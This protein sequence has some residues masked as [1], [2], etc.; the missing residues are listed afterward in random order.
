MIAFVLLRRSAKKLDQLHRCGNVY[1]KALM[2]DDTGDQL[3]V[4][5][6]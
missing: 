4:Q 6:L 1:V 3:R 2:K 5:R